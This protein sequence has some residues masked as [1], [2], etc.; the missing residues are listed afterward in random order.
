L[1]VTTQRGEPRAVGDVVVRDLLGRTASGFENHAGRT[2][3]GRGLDALGAVTSGIGNGDG[4]DGARAG[5]IVATYLHGPVLAR[6]AWLADQL[7]SSV[8]GGELAPLEDRAEEVLAKERLAAAGSDRVSIGEAR[9]RI[10][11]QG[12]RALVSRK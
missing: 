9:R 1:D 5:R 8:I 12:V 10:L 3:R 2:S 6:N 4:S 11:Q 7:L